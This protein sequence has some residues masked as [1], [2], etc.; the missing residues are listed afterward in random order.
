MKNAY[1][2]IDHHI[3]ISKMGMKD[4]YFSIDH[5][6]DILKICMYTCSQ[7]YTFIVSKEVFNQ[8]MS[9]GKREKLG[10]KLGY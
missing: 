5:H 4:A 10:I 7:T 1:L 3:N 6:I 2:S 9:T 8:K